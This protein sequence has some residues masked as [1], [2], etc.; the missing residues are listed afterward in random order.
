[1][2][3]LLAYDKA[4][5]AL[6]TVSLYSNIFS[7]DSSIGLSLAFTFSHLKLEES[8]RKQLEIIRKYFEGTYNINFLLASDYASKGNFI[9]AIKEMDLA[10]EID[11]NES[12][13]YN[14][15][16][17]YKSKIG[18]YK[19]SILDF[20]KSI[21]LNPKQYFSHNNLGRSKTMLGDKSGINDIKYSIKKD[22][23]NAVA[24]INLAI[25]ESKFGNKDKIPLL[26]REAK[27]KKYYHQVQLEI[28][29]LRSL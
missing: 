9:E 1:V 22:S 18:L 13:I 27:S 26:I 4:D 15:R 28:K 25:W 21:E 20:N 29:M 12:I 16:G 23:N 24:F 7:L 19:E 17:Y 5:K 2:F 6:K 3:N 10:L 8:F 11:K 14:N